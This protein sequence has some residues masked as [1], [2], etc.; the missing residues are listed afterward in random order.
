MRTTNL[1]I[2]RWSRVP[3]S[4]S[5]MATCPSPAHSDHIRYADVI[6]CAAARIVQAVRQKAQE[7]NPQNTE[8]AFDSLQ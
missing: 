4:Y 8:G 3:S 1:F 2:V 7:Y 6:Q 5:H